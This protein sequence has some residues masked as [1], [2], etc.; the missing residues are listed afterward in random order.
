MNTRRT[1]RRRRVLREEVVTSV[2]ATAPQSL[3][4]TEGTTPERKQ[5]RYFSK[6]KRRHQPRLT[7][8]IPVRTL[9]LCLI[10]IGL[11]AM[12]SLMCWLDYFIRTSA[13]LTTF[14]AFLFGE[15][16]SIA[17]W[18]QS[19]GMLVTAAI[20]YL[21]Y[22]LRSHRCDDYRGTYRIWCGLALICLFASATS[23]ISVTPAIL[24][25]FDHLSWAEQINIEILLK[26]A[27]IVTVLLVSVRIWFELR[28]SRLAM[29]TFYIAVI[30]Y[31]GNVFLSNGVLR[32]ALN[33][34]IFENAKG[35]LL[36]I[37]HFAWLYGV[38]LFA[39]YVYL[40]AHGLIKKPVKVEKTK[41]TKCRSKSTKKQNDTNKAKEKEA[42]PAHRGDEKSKD[43]KRPSQSPPVKPM[44]AKSSSKTNE[45]PKTSTPPEKETGEL[46]ELEEKAD[47]Q[48]LSKAERRRLRKLARRNQRAA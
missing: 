47:N 24:Y 35:G 15:Q 2:T 14:A 48:G 19:T 13:D 46:T 34:V 7:D 37:A 30:A 36:L 3:E 41:I 26:I 44:V 21:I 6:A 31:F 12:L 42:F 38:L 23:H 8:L 5:R 45:K 40:D 39:R 33:E 1:D 28:H 32:A 29:S 10:G 18:M 25:G 43:I 4:S 22:V 27:G 11:L 16:A 17:N 9:P 20:C